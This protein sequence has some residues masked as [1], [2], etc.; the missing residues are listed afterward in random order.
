MRGHEVHYSRPEGWNKDSVS[1][2]FTVE[3]VFGFDGRRDGGRYKNVL[4]LYTHIHALGEQR[5][6]DAMIRQAELHQQGGVN[7]HW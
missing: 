2:A 5:W 6:A 1:F 4:C 7:F 3:Q